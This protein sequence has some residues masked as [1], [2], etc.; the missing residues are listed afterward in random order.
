MR[1]I[2]RC[3]KEG[4]PKEIVTEEVVLGEV[5]LGEVVPGKVIPGRLCQRRLSHW[6]LFQGRLSGKKIE[7]NKMKKIRALGYV[8]KKCKETFEPPVMR[9]KQPAQPGLALQEAGSR[10]HCTGGTT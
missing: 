1:N 4:D 2:R 10:Q 8:Q 6:R 9:L 3:P 7:A 5:V